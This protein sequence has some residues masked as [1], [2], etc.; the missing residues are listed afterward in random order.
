MKPIALLAVLAASAMAG[1]WDIGQVDSAGWGEGVQMRWHPD[2][3][4]FLCYSDTSGRIRLASF[5]T[6]WQ[7][8]NVPTESQPDPSSQ[9]F[10]ISPAGHV[11]ITYC[12]NRG[13]R[14]IEKTDSGWAEMPGY[15][16]SWYRPLP[17]YRLD[18]T[19]SYVLNEGASV[20]NVFRD[21]TGWFPETVVVYLDGAIIECWTNRVLPDG[22]QVCSITMDDQSIMMG[23]LAYFVR[24]DDRWQAHDYGGVYH[25]GFR[26]IG[27]DVDTSDSIRLCYGWDE[28][29]P[30]QN[31]FFCYE[32]TTICSVEPALSVLDIDTLNRPQIA[33][34]GELW[35]TYGDSFGWHNRL[36]DGRSV[37]ALDMVLGDSCQPIIAYA[38]D[39]GLFLA[40]G[41]DVTGQSEE[42]RG[43]TV[44]GSRLT[45][46]IVR[47]ILRIP[48][49]PST[50]H[51]SLFDM[52]GCLVSD[53]HPGANDVSGLVPGVYFVREKP[54]AS[55]SKLQAVQKVIITR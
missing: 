51:A 53:L 16:S 50:I 39:S 8:E 20:M 4:L 45:A 25:G 19:F 17:A 46:T 23:H 34:S 2:G 9:G 26:A 52:T 28:W 35:Y 36:V 14:F 41:V 18:G 30:N 21:T 49:S 1:H 6:A 55:S 40:R 48:V 5:D 47:G 44:R 29:F 37:L 33:Y 12:R 54:Q 3:R 22:R 11:G 31:D 24:A 38:V 15:S 10:D 7:Y 42:Q 43:P 32:T 27:C 13:V